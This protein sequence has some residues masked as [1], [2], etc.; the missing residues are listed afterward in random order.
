MSRP[1]HASHNP[2]SE[3]RSEREL[4]EYFCELAARFL[5]FFCN[6]FDRTVIGGAVLH[7]A[8][9]RIREHLPA[10]ALSHLFAL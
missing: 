7:Q 1:S 4:T 10:D 3:Y 2:R 5:K 8:A 9:E 6:L